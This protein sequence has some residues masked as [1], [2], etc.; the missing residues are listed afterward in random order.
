MSCPGG[1]PPLMPDASCTGPKKKSPRRIRRRSAAL[2]PGQ[3]SAAV[4]AISTISQDKG[5]QANRRE[6]LSLPASGRCRRGSPARQA[7]LP[8][9]AGG[10]RPCEH[11]WAVP[12][13][14]WTAPGL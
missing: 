13:Q 12:A 2:L 9:K 11:N 14:C 7:R 4:I 8:R 10:C 3:I 6:E 5:V 1:A